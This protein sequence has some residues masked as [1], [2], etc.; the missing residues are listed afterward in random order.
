MTKA[1]PNT[2][3]TSDDV[4]LAAAITA[5]NEGAVIAGA[6]TR[7]MAVLYDGMLVLAMLFLV[8]LVL[9]SIGTLAFGEVGTTATQAKEL[10]TWYTNVVL[11]PSF[12]LTLVGFY[13]LFWRKSGQTLGMQTWRLKTV[14]SNGKLLTWQQST[15]RILCACIVPVVCG[16]LGYVMYGNKGLSASLVSGFVLNYLFCLVN[17]RGLAVHDLLSNTLTIKI[18]KTIHDTLWRS[19]KGKGKQQG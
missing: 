4:K 11:T 19:V 10:P 17:R 8:S 15:I 7:L 5:Q 2:A 13:G 14:A 1:T 16:A 6:G 12:V 3:P 9:I 18:P